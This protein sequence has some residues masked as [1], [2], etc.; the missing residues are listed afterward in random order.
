MAMQ[1]QPDMPALLVEAVGL[2]PDLRLNGFF[3]I[4]KYRF[5]TQQR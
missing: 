4:K 1:S 5:K 3:G 2:K